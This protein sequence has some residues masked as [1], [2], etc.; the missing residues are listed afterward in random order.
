MATHPLQKGFA[1]YADFF[2]RASAA[3]FFTSLQTR[4][5]DYNAINLWDLNPEIYGSVEHVEDVELPTYDK[6]Q[7]F[8]FCDYQATFTKR[9]CLFILRGMPQGDYERV[10]VALNA[11]MP[12]TFPLNRDAYVNIWGRSPI[13]R[14]NMV[15]M[16]HDPITASEKHERDQQ[17]IAAFLREHPTILDSY[18]RKA[19]LFLSTV[20]NLKTAKRK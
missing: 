1:N 4:I 11:I 5:A 16:L 8:S 14:L 3:G 20:S 2:A 15:D 6:D 12:D 19:K 13:A 9:I 7:R 10:G 17:E 18:H